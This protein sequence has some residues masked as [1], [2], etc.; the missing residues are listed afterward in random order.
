[1]IRHVGTG[2]LLRICWRRRDNR[3]DK[4]NFLFISLSEKMNDVENGDWQID[5]FKT[6]FIEYID[7]R[8][9]H[10]V[11]CGVLCLNKIY[12]ISNFSC[13]R[14]RKLYLLRFFRMY[15]LPQWRFCRR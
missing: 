4:D 5:E 12:Y 1:M 6:Q 9:P 15:H 8:K 14:M 3:F 10:T 11:L 7:T 2:Y 13:Q